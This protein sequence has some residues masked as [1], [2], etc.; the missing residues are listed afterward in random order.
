V[1]TTQRNS[2][3]RFNTLE[4]WR[5]LPLKRQYA[6]AYVIPLRTS[7]CYGGH[8]GILW[9]FPG[10]SVMGDTP[11]PLARHSSCLSGRVGDRPSLRGFGLGLW[12]WSRGD[13]ATIGFGPMAGIESPSRCQRSSFAVRQVRPFYRNTL[14]FSTE[15]GYYITIP[16]QNA[17]GNA[18]KSQSKTETHEPVTHLFGLTVV[19]LPSGSC[20]TSVPFSE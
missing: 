5:S 13:R 17:R 9:G 4:L 1:V 6:V 8:A 16:P 19:M 11:S 14:A 12:R 10:S 15:Q 20:H 18:Q 2:V 3:S 7:L